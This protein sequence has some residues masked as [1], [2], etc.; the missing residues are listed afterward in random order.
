MRISNFLASS[1]AVASSR[2]AP[3]S[4][5]SS[6][7]PSSSSS[8]YQR[9]TLMSITSSAASDLSA[10]I[11]AEA[12]IR[13]S[14]SNRAAWASTATS[15]AS[16]PT[17]LVASV[18]N[19]ATDTVMSTVVEA[20]TTKTVDV[21][22]TG[23]PST[24]VAPSTV[25]VTSTVTACPSSTTTSEPSETPAGTC[26]LVYY[27]QGY[28]VEPGWTFEISGSHWS[29]KALKHVAERCGAV[30]DFKI[31]SHNDF[32]AF[33]WTVSGFSRKR[34]GMG[35][36]EGGLGCLQFE[37]QQ[38][39]AP[40]KL[41]CNVE[42]QVPEM[43]ATCFTHY[44]TLY[45]KFNI[46]GTRAW[47]HEHVEHAASICGVV[48]HFEIVDFCDLQSPYADS[49]KCL[50]GWSWH[51][52]GRLGVKLDLQNS[53]LEKYLKKYTDMPAGAKCEVWYKPQGV[54][55]WTDTEYNIP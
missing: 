18:S 17:T 31:N 25:T 48:S 41:H 15:K 37:L 46:Q 53:C 26:K 30:T 12:I 27:D 13:N 20:V 4:T 29:P 50:Y 55:Q 33:E 49:D 35:G 10:A 21:W 19:D 8:P 1:V 52:T 23:N 2:Y 28:L 7:V 24:R 32:A 42:R 22:V 14:T 47:S 3:V 6:T 9:S 5:A 43:A 38:E 36:F 44:W 34:Y 51:A 54:G 39:G 45:D 16:R 40:A 11:S